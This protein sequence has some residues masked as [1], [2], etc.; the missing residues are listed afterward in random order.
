MPRFKKETYGNPFTNAFVAEMEGIEANVR[1]YAY[2]DAKDNLYSHI[3]GGIILPTFSHKGYLLT[4][5]VKYDDTITFDCID[6]FETDDAYELVAKAKEIQKEY[7]EGIITN[8]WGD[9]LQLMSIV[10]EL[11]IEDT[12]QEPVRISSPID[13]NQTD[14]FE[15]Y[16]ARIKVALNKTH[17]TLYLGETNLVR[18]YIMSFI[19]EKGAKQDSNPSIYVLGSVVH[20][21]LIM[22]PW[23]QA[24]EVTDLVPTTFED[25]AR[26]EHDQAMKH[27]QN[28]LEGGLI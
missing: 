10:N 28:N 11:N 1:D 23:E 18:N 2:R 13:Y 6:E 3:T 22:R 27:I 9:P 17:K 4:V 19:E 16:T 15:I 20:T 25:I 12:K 5:G 7:G 14:N 24:V 26:Y 8:W 21:L